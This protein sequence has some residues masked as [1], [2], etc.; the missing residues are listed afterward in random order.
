MLVPR[1]FTGGGLFH[2]I[3]LILATVCTQKASI[4]FI[5]C[6]VAILLLADTQDSIL[7]LPALLSSTPVVLY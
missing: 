6:S 2:L 5:V 1:Y 4:I 3:F 7:S